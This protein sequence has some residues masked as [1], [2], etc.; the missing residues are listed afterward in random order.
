MARSGTLEPGNLAAHP[1]MAE[2]ILDGT[3]EGAGKLA[4]RERGRVVAGY[5]L[6]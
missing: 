6:G 2:T 5:G 3:L 4:D 1:D